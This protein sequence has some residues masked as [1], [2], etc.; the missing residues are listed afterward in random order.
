MTS[1]LFSAQ[2]QLPSLCI[3]DRLSDLAGRT[4][5]LRLERPPLLAE[6]TPCFALLIHPADQSARVESKEDRRFDS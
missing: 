1:G 6:W 5:L 4:T 2:R 3:L